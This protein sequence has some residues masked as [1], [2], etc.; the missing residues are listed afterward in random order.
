MRRGASLFSR[1]DRTAGKTGRI[2]TLLLVVAVFGSVL[3]IIIGAPFSSIPI[4]D[5][6]I[7]M[8]LAVFP[9][10]L[11]YIGAILAAY[12]LL[13]LL[14]N[15]RRPPSLPSQVLTFAASATLVLWVGW[16]V[17]SAWNRAAGVGES[18]SSANW[19]PLNFAHEDSIALVSETDQC[20]AFCLSLLVTGRAKQVVL[21]RAERWPLSAAALAG[22]RR[23]RLGAGWRSCFSRLTDFSLVVRSYPDDRLDEFQ[24]LGL[25]PFFQQDVQSCLDS[26]PARLDPIHETVLFNWHQYPGG[27]SPPEEMPIGLGPIIGEQ[28]IAIPGE[29]TPSS[30]ALRFVRRYDVPASISPYA[31]NAAV[32]GRF[33]PR[34]SAS[35]VLT[36]SSGDRVAASW[37]SMITD[38]SAL[39]RQ[40]VVILDATVADRQPDF[41]AHDR[42]PSH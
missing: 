40:A 34:W 4:F 35:D 13:I 26:T 3:T 1:I 5:F 8:P 6:L 19:R 42:N 25:E 7:G 20:G 2:L 36:I 39:A 10:L 23:V 28:R 32:G 12:L 31:G 21:A 27:R 24:Q 18:A 15:G 37:W 14:M 11:M 41:T 22:A 33:E 38:G 30:R 9:T 29:R 16:A 17:P